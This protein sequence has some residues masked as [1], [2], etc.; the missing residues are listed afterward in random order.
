[1]TLKKVILVEVINYTI[2]KLK[3]LFT[4]Y[5]DQKIIAI[6]GNHDQSTKNILG[7]KAESALSHLQVIFPDNFR[8]ID[9]KLLRLKDVTLVGIPYYEYP[10]NFKQVLSTFSKK[11]SNIRNEGSKVILMMHQTPQGLDNVNI[12]SDT[13]VTDSLYK[14]FDLI[15]NGHIHKKQRLSDKFIIIGNPL[16]RDLGDE[17]DEKGFYVMD[18]EGLPKSIRFVSLNEVAGNFYPEFKKQ[19][20]SNEYDEIKEDNLNYIVPIVVEEDGF[21]EGDDDSM[22]DFDSSLKDK[23]LVENYWKSAEG[24]NEKLLALGLRFLKK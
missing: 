22:K 24:K 4:E 1:M 11:V 19:V 2:Q 13:D 15:L 20:I 3:E 5:S 6:T 9:N 21:L 18:T 14:P 23:E 16:H 10:E 8:I 7:N 17:G 12:P